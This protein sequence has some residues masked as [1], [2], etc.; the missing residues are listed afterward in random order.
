MAIKFQFSGLSADIF[1]KYLKYFS[2]ITYAA[3]CAPP[4]PPLKSTVL[5]KLLTNN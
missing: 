1:L 2:S 3:S 4:I 5:G